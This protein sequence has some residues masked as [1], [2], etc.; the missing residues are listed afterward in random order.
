MDT[1]TLVEAHIG[2]EKLAQRAIS[3]L[4]T[5]IERDFGLR[6][7]MGAELEF[8]Y[9]NFHDKHHG[10]ISRF[11]AKGAGYKPYYLR[12]DADGFRIPNQ[13]NSSYLKNQRYVSHFYWDI[14]D[15]FS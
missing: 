11:W 13:I 6:V 8:G 3:L 14:N 7:I 1:T 10:D 12:N 9:Y 4:M 2:Y 15:S 5:A